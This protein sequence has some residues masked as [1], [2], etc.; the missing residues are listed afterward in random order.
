MKIKPGMVAAITG[1]G[2]GIG[3]ALALEL[4]RRGCS[5]ALADIDGTRLEQTAQQAQALSA[6]VTS[7]VLDVSDRAAVFFWADNTVAALGGVNMIFNN[8]GV[9]LTAM[10]EATQPTDFEWLMGI[11]FWGVVNGTQAFL[12]RLRATGEGHVVNISSLFGLMAMPTQGAYNASKFAVRG[13]TEA[14]RMELELEGGQVSATCVHPGGVATNIALAGRIDDGFVRRTGVEAQAHRE[15][16]NQML[17]VTTPEAA[18]AQI[19]AGI[20]RNAARVLVGSDARRMD[21]WIRLLGAGYQ[22]LVLKRVRKLRAQALA[23]RREAA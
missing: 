10:A 22:Q 21:W 5:L 20:E 12:P 13:F 2:S 15:R 23:Q 17:Q 6:P 14:L 8:A 11:N 4:A 16:A 18:A 9:A 3:R 19:I 7:T 1:A